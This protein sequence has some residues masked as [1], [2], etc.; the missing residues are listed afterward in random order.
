MQVYGHGVAGCAQED[1]TGGGT[2]MAERTGDQHL[3]SLFRGRMLAEIQIW[4]GVASPARL[5]ASSVNQGDDTKDPG[6]PTPALPAHRLAGAVGADGHGLT[7]E[8]LAEVEADATPSHIDPMA[9][10]GESPERSRY[11][12]NAAMD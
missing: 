9:Y 5:R 6:A 4:Q 8:L 12:A 2:W 3:L 10:E 7:D 1:V 11:V